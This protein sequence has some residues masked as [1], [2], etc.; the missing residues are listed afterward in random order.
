MAVESRQDQRAA[1]PSGVP[2][3]Y[4]AKVRSI[5]YQ[6]VAVLL[7]LAVVGYLTNNTITNL[8][9][10]GIATGFAF[11]RHPTGFGI[12]GT[13]GTNLV[14]YSESSTYARAFMVGI[15]NTL[16]VSVVG[17]FL[18]TMVG[19]LLGV[20]RLS[21]N[22]LISKLATVYIE[23]IRNVPLLLQILFW[24]FGVLT[25]LPR[26]KQSLEFRGAFFLNNRGLYSPRPIF[27]SGA[28]AIAIA[29]AIGVVGTIVLARWAKRRQEL[30]GQRFP[31]FLSAL[32]LIIGLP[33]LAT[34]A[35]GVPVTWE[36]PVLKGFN[37]QGGLV[38][39]PEFMA[40]L[41]ALVAY[42][43]AFIGEIVRAGIQSVSRGQTEAAHSLGVRPGPTL[44]LV[45]I[46]QAL[47]VIIPPLTSQFLNLTKN[48]SLAA[49]IGYPEL[50][51]VFSGTVLNQTGQ[52]VECIALTMLVYFTI[53]LCIS[54]YMNW[55]NKRMALVER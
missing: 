53:S 20:A 18:A 36:Y 31:V 28:V 15:L 12:A 52:A 43:G 9:K 19:F 50:V 46:P 8:E 13:V 45:I 33:V 30:T 21:S 24:Y 44:R 1:T 41:L 39:I 26:L 42:T 35:T 40:L 32:G 11:L 47:R 49:A 51:A 25:A 16:F 10:R 7:F 22:W 6:I 29:F 54:L 27:E 37:F 14:G 17:I 38:V 5:F 48:S 4:D 23:I 55:Y 2:F 34:L 3:W